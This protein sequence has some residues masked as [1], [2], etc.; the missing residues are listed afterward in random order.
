LI[1]SFNIELTGLELSLVEFG[2]S[3]DSSILC[4]KCVLCHWSVKTPYDEG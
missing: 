3:T 2:E 1:L 4:M